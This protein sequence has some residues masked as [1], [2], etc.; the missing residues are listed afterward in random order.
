MLNDQEERTMINQAIKKLPR[1]RIRPATI[2]DLEKV[3]Q[4]DS[5]ITQIQKSQY[6]SDVFTRSIGQPGHYFLVTESALDK[7]TEGSLIG[8]IVGEVR[9]W[10][11][12]SE[13]CGWVV[14]ILVS[15]NF[16]DLA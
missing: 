1:L 11:F 16:K 8:F 2:S 15:P 5:R 7:R 3:I 14:T 10:E 9:A 12:G 6:W 4:L 13:P